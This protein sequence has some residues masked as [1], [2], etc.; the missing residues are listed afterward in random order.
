MAVFEPPGE[1]LPSQDRAALITPEMISFLRHAQP[2]VRFLALYGFVG[3][4]MTAWSALAAWTRPGGMLVGVVQ[5]GLAMVNLLL[6]FPL[7]RFAQ[8]IER[9]RPGSGGAPVEE[10]LAQQLAVFRFL[11][12]V[13]LLEAALVVLA[14]SAPVLRD[15]AW[16][17]DREPPPRFSSID[18][19]C[20]TPAPELLC[21]TVA[22]F[23]TRGRLTDWTGWHAFT[24]QQGRF[25]FDSSSSNPVH[26]TFFG[27]SGNNAWE[28]WLRAPRGKVLLPGEY[29][30]A[31]PASGDYT[32][33]RLALMRMPPAWFPVES[34]RGQD[35]AWF[36]ECRQDWFPYER[37][38]KRES[39]FT[40]RKI[41]WT[42]DGEL[43]RIVADFEQSCTTSQGTMVV[44]GRIRAT[45]PA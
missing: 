25:R 45:R 42:P 16:W 1:A 8:A 15:L 20:D 18:E 44:L 43:R 41:L 39:R 32:A 17:V 12:I 38:A 35:P 26:L 13:A 19:A 24:P 30:G 11:G 22:V 10:A 33:P 3:A 2:W 31:N 29:T 14:I 9:V 6:T 34:G 7:F 4:A 36:E 5:W 40:V 37:E 28:I 23:D 21:A 27:E